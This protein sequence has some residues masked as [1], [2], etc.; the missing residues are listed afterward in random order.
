MLERREFLTRAALG[1]L[2]AP[3][4]SRELLAG[5]LRPA[6]AEIEQMVCADAVPL[7]PRSLYDT[8]PERYWA[9]LRRQWLLA[10]DRINLNCGSIGCSP[11]PVLRSLVEHIL[12]AEEFREQPFPWYGYEENERLRNLREALAAFLGCTR[13][14]LALARNATE[15]NNLVTGGLDFQQSDEILLTDQE[16]PGGR[17]PWEQKAARFGLKL[18]YVTLPKPP[19]SSAEI[20]ERFERALTPRTK[21]M[22]F[23]H[24]TTVTGVVLPAKEICR[25]ARDRGILT[26]VDGAHAIGQLPLNLHDMGCDFYTTSPHKWVMAPKGTGTLY[27]RAELLDRL[28]VNLCSGDWNKKELKAWRFSNVGTSNLSVFVGLKAALDF[29]REI[30]PERIY[31]RQHQLATRVRDGVNAQPQ[32]KVV[33]ASKDEFFGAL[34]SFEPN[35]ASQA[36]AP[37]DLSGIAKQCS[38]RRIRIAGGTERIRIATNIFAQPTEI[39]FFFDAVAAG[40]RA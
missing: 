30:G 18:N 9:E 35:T 21:L 40:L 17:G 39:N 10:P 25:L 11:L 6:L 16:H 24:I 34:V 29:F 4:A 12:Y 3:A 28:W 13:D 7:P 33:N 23:S 26:Q 2:F 19:A 27:I 5:P 32:L 22:L 31:A 1:A 38:D 15:A 8:D 14:E 20:L 37:K 36:N